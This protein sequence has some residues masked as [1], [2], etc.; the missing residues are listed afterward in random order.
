ML[1]YNNI[2]KY[3]SSARLNRY[4]QV[5]NNDNK[6]VL[7]LYQTNLRLSQ[8]FYP[9][10]SLFEIVLR[11]AIN[12]E[13][14]SFYN[15]PNWLSNQRNNL[16]YR[17]T[18]AVTGRPIE[19]RFLEKK[20]SSILRH[21]GGR[22][23]NGKIVSELIFG[24]WTELFS[25][26]F[27]PLVQGQPMRIFNSLPS[28]TSRSNISRRLK[29][30]RDFR[31]RIY[32]NEPIIFSV[33][34]NGNSI[35]SLSKCQNIYSELKVFFQYFNIDF[36]TWTRKIDNVEFEINRAECVDA[37]YPKNTYYLNNL[38]LSAKHMKRKYL[39]N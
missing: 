39:Q 10:L 16:I 5:C 25:P 27:F 18:D 32:H 8:A 21:N 1:N 9:L 12:D 33:D 14:I 6:R 34:Q 28:N 31:N 2:R 26:K 36:T 23:A 13:M 20:I 24:F 7:K 22:V 3:I 37:L 11:N 29:D 35:F 38:I 4:E 17:S 15:D 30:I 19:N